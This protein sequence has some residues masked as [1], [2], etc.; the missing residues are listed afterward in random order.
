LRRFELP[1]RLRTLAE[2]VGSCGCLW[3]VGTDHG[4]LP[5]WLLVNGKIRS[6]IASDIRK[7]PLE[8]AERT[9]EA[10]N[11]KDSMIFILCDGLDAPAGLE[12]DVITIAGMGG[13]TI[14][15]I[16]DRAPWVADRKTRLLLQP[17]S[18]IEDLREYL[19]SGRYTVLGERLVRERDKLYLIIEAIGGGDPEPYDLKDTRIG[20][21]LVRDAEFADYA[22][23]EMRRLRNE[24]LGADSRKKAAIHEAL[25][26]IAAI[27]EETENDHGTR[28]I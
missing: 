7:G 25:R 6:A 23:R 21:H 17:M 28:H 4:K 16:L 9:A 10:N 15:G 26:R 20:K 24:L 18:S 5:V 8:S 14:A 2:L 12:A 1:P 19:Y 3:D 22:G 11:V 13:D 27:K